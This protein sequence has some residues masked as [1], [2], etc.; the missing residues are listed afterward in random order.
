MTSLG[1]GNNDINDNDDN[2]GPD[3]E[4]IGNEHQP[5]LGSSVATSNNNNNNNQHQHHQHDVIDIKHTTNGSPP[6]TAATGAAGSTSTASSSSSSSS[7][8]SGGSSSNS[9]SSN[10]GVKDVDNVVVMDPLSMRVLI[11][12]LSLFFYEAVELSLYRIWYGFNVYLAGIEGISL[13]NYAWLLAIGDIAAIL[14]IFIAGPLDRVKARTVFMTAGVFQCVITFA[15]APVASFAMAMCYRFLYGLCRA[16]LA[17]S[18]AVLIGEQL[19]ARHHA[20]FTGLL[21]CSW[22]VAGVIGYLVTGYLLHDGVASYWR[23]PFFVFGGL[24]SAMLILLFIVLPPR[25]RYQSGRLIVST[26]QS[27]AHS[28]GN[29]SDGTTNTNDIDD[30]DD[31]GRHTAAPMNEV[32]KVSLPIWSMIFFAAIGINVYLGSLGTWLTDLKGLSSFQLGATLSLFL[33]GA[34]LAS[35]VITMIIAHLVGVRFGSWLPLAVLLTVATYFGMQ[36]ITSSDQYN[37]LLA[38]VAFSSLPI[39]FAVCAVFSVGSSIVASMNRPSVALILQGTYSMGVSVGSAMSTVVYESGYMPTTAAV[40]FLI[41]GVCTLFMKPIPSIDIATNTN[42]TID[43][44]AA[45]PTIGTPSIPS[46]TT[47]SSSSSSSTSTA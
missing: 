43:P 17:S 19:P 15:M 7:S 27:S 36:F 25:P 34:N 40:S 29:S 42:I 31:H 6:P 18:I 39:E 44:S 20:T 24:M 8:S 41:A 37:T 10:G 3:D 47:S 45:T 11:I 35:E 13:S 28:N 32:I 21:Q 1:G 16:L 26:P 12:F 38:L 5:L 14:P 4:S 30:D 9:N 22:G 33:G 46:N 2:N 23:R